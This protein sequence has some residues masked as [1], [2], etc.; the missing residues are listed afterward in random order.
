MELFTV[1]VILYCQ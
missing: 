1:E